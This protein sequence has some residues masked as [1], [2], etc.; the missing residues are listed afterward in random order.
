MKSHDLANMLLDGPDLDVILQKDAEG[1][2]YSPL[3]GADNLCIYVPDSTWSGEVYSMNW[4]AEDA[5]M[6]ASEWDEFKRE[7]QQVVVLFPV[8]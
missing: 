1:K 8:N 5:C 6:E 4:S 2:E 7:N 3:E